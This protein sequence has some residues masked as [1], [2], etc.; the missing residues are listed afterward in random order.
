MGRLSRSLSL[1]IPRTWF[2]IVAVVLAA[3]ECGLRAAGYGRFVLT[4]TSERYGWRYPPGLEYVDAPN[5][6]P[7]RIN[8]FGFRDS[9]WPEPERDPTKLRIAVLGNSVM[10]GG[11]GL[12]IEQRCDRVLAREMQARLDAAGDPRRVETLDFALP[13]Y[14]FEQCARIWEDEVRPFR[15]DVLLVTLLP[16]DVR[17]MRRMRDAP[18]YPFSRWVGRSATRDW[19]QRTLLGGWGAGMDPEQRRIELAVRAAPFAPEH[20]GLWSAMLA[21][22]DEVRAQAEAIG[23]RTVVVSLPTVESVARPEAERIGKR[24]EP[25]AAE[26]G[27]LHVDPQ[28]EFEDAMRPLLDELAKAGLPPER[29]WGRARDPELPSRLAHGDATCFFFQDPDHLTAIGHA[30]L[31]RALAS[32]LDRTHP[33]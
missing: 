23:A 9:E 16:Y 27:V 11:G 30:L 5:P 32:G 29:A 1:R 21:R 12:E 13:G 6:V 25:W 10:W 3:T 8:R 17:P 20:D 19:V 2:L 28:R 4:Y 15:P 7:V 18:R 22:L 31:A 33:W 24:L 14:T 26:R